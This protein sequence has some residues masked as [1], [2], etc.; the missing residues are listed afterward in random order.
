MRVRNS[1][2]NIA[3]GVGSQLVS[4]GMGFAARTAFVATLG[5]E[6]L[7][8][9]GLFTSVLML[10][11]LA[12]LGFDTAIVYSLYKP[13]AER[14]ER[15]IEA[16]MTLF[17]NAYRIV[18][19]VVFVLGLALL[20]FLPALIRGGT[21]VEHLHWIYLLFLVQ[22]ASSYYFVYKQSVLIADQKA[23]VISK[24][25][26]VFTIVSN[27]LQIALLLVWGQYLVV[28]AAQIAIRVAENVYIARRAEREYPFLRHMRGAKLSADERKTFFENVYS[29]LLYRISGVVIHGTDNVVISKFVGLVAVGV[30]S[31][32]L[33]VL[34]TVNMFLGY[35]FHSV[36]A[37]VGHLHASE[38]AEKQHQ[39][40]RV[41][42]FANFWAYG[43]AA[44]ALWHG[45]NPFLTAWLGNGH[46]FGA[47]A[48]FAIVA[49]FLTGGM[50]NAATAFRETTGLFKKGK[51]RPLIAAAIN[52]AVSVALAPTLGVAGV[53]LG[54]VVS[55]LCTYFWF[56]P[57]IVYKHVFARPTGAY[58]AAYARYMALIA[59]AGAASAGAVALASAGLASAYGGAPP[60]ALDLALRL[61]LGV[62]VPNALF[63]A[64]C[65]RTA[66]FAYV[67]AV[68]ASLAA[69]AVA[70]VRGRKRALTRSL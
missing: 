23:H 26:T 17:R 31:N 44:I 58:F 35:V 61:A 36:T 24:I 6:L 2:R 62:A 39:V 27:G 64:A 8:V 10:L 66:E 68:A 45:L 47:L 37:S 65:R 5:M 54:T 52:L 34:S 40:F 25:H 33:L 1:V 14:D 3:F 53:L 43:C 51:Y 32:Y 19:A 38:S 28:L 49:N 20:P 7:G 57:Y 18:G 13:L 60:A 48:V 46:T 55:R 59:A 21:T 69:N 12:N 11:S 63:Y 50:Q 30:Y 4:A 16:Y 70:V 56:D 15:K 41:L 22:S 29:L 67:R 9:D 42:L